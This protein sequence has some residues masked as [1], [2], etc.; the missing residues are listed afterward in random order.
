MF[1]IHVWQG[2]CSGTPWHSKSRSKFPGI[3]N[4]VT[5]GALSTP[6]SSLRGADSLAECNY[7]RRSVVH[8]KNIPPEEAVRGAAALARDRA[9]TMPRGY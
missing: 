1:G 6:C 5:H 3:G 8:Y 7:T 2:S 9:V 4:S